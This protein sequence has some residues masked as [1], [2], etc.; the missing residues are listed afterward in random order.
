VEQ[1]A[2]MLTNTEFDAI[3][4]STSK[5]ING[6]IKWQSD[7][8]HSPSLEF[9][10]EVHSEAG[11]P[12]SIR[13]SYNPLIPAVSYVLILATSGRIYGLDLGKDHHNPECN[14]VGERHKHKWSV[15]NRDKQAYVPKDI[16]EPASDPVAVWK[17]FCA[18]ARLKH[19]GSMLAPPPPQGDLF[20]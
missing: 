7:E 3:L 4:E 5:Q 9:L 15:Q 2:T 8:D 6:D 19:E 17:Q 13:G 10:A 16:T 11:W 12:L 14:C 1:G 20:T 18:E